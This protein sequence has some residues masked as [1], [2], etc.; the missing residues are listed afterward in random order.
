MPQHVPPGHLD[1]EQTATLLGVTRGNLRILVH[2][3]HLKPSGGTDRHPLYKIDDVK[4]LHNERA[5]RSGHPGN[6][7]HPSASSLDAQVSAV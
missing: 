7:E 3:G 4:R 5:T 6:L 1:A 2:R